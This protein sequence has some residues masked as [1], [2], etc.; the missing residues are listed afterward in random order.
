[1]KNSNKN[2]SLFK[3]MRLV[4]INEMSE[5]PHMN[6]EKGERID[7][8][9]MRIKAIST[10][11]SKEESDRLKTEEYEATTGVFISSADQKRRLTVMEVDMACGQMAGKLYGSNLMARHMQT[12]D[13]V[14]AFNENPL[15]GTENLT[16]K[17]QK[18]DPSYKS[19][20]FSKE[21][22]KDYIQIFLED[23]KGN[24]NEI[25]KFDI[26][27][28]ARIKMESKRETLLKE[29]QEQRSGLEKE[30]KNI[31][32]MK[33]QVAEYKLKLINKPINL[34]PEQVE[35]QHD[36]LV[37]GKTPET[38]ALTCWK[39][40]SEGKRM[41]KSATIIFTYENG[42]YKYKVLGSNPASNPEHT[43][44]GPETKEFTIP[45]FTEVEKLIQSTYIDAIQPSTAQMSG[46]EFVAKIGDKILYADHT[47]A[48][49]TADDIPAD[50]E[51]KKQVD[52]KALKRATKKAE[53]KRL[54]KMVEEETLAESAVEPIEED[55][56]K[57]TKTPTV[58]VEKIQ[59]KIVNK[60]EL[61]KDPDTNLRTLTITTKKGTK[62]VYKEIGQRT[63][64]LRAIWRYADSDEYYLDSG[65]RV[66]PSGFDYTGTGQKESV[67]LGK[68]ANIVRDT[69]RDVEEMS[70]ADVT[71]V[72]E[73]SLTEDSRFLMSQGPQFVQSKLDYYMRMTKEKLDAKEDH[74]VYSTL[75]GITQ[76][77][78]EGGIS[79]SKDL[80]KFYENITVDFHGVKVEWTKE[81]GF[82][83]PEN[84]D[85][86]L[87]KTIQMLKK[88]LSKEDYE[89]FR[90]REKTLER[91]ADLSQAEELAEKNNRENMLSKL[92]KTYKVKAF[93]KK[94]FPE[95]KML[96]N[97]K[98]LDGNKA[99]M[100]ALQR[101]NV[102]SLAQGSHGISEHEMPKLA[103]K[104]ITEWNNKR[105]DYKEVLKFAKPNIEGAFRQKTDSNALS[106]I[107]GKKGL[108]LE[109]M[110]DPSNLSEVIEKGLI[111]AEKNELHAEFM[112]RVFL[113]IV[114]PIIELLESLENLAFTK[115]EKDNTPKTTEDLIWGM[116]ERG[117]EHYA[118]FSLPAG[119]RFKLDQVS[120]Y[121]NSKNLEIGID[122]KL[123][124]QAKEG[125]KKQ[126]KE[127]LLEDKYTPY[128]DKIDNKIFLQ[129]LFLKIS[130]EELIKQGCLEMNTGKQLR[131][132]K[133][134]KEIK[135][136][137]I[138]ILENV[139]S[140]VDGTLENYSGHYEMDDMGLGSQD[141]VEDDDITILRNKL[142]F[143]DRQTKA[144]K[145]LKDLCDGGD[146][147]GWLKQVVD[148]C[149]G[150]ENFTYMTQLDGNALLQDR[151]RLNQQMTSDA[152]FNYLMYHGEYYDVD[153]VRG[154]K[155]LNIAKLEEEV[156]KFI[157][158]G[159]LQMYLS[160]G[161]EKGEAPTEEEVAEALKPGSEFNKELNELKISQ[162]GV[163]GLGAG[164]LLEK[165]KKAFQLGLLVEYNTK[166]EE[167][168]DTLKMPKN[169]AM[170]AWMEWAIS[171]GAKISTV[172]S[173]VSK[174][175]AGMAVIAGGGNTN[176]LFGAGCNFNL[177]GGLSLGVHAT[178]S[179]GAGVQLAYS[180]KAGNSTFT[181][182]VAVTGDIT[183]G[184][185]VLLGAQNRH[186][187][188]N[189]AYEG[190]AMAGLLSHSSTAFIP[191]PALA[192]G[193]GRSYT[194][195]VDLKLGETVKEKGF[196]KIQ[197]LLKEYDAGKKG[198]EEAVL[199]EARNIPQFAPL[200]D[201][202]IGGKVAISNKMIISL[203]KFQL[204]D[205]Q[206][207]SAKSASKSL[208][209]TDW[210]PIS[211]IVLGIPTY[212]KFSIPAGTVSRPLLK[213]EARL[214]GINS[215]MAVEDELE[216]KL[217][218]NELTGIGV[219]NM[220]QV[221]ITADGRIGRLI[222]KTQPVQLDFSNLSDSNL[223]NSALKDVNM[224]VEE[225]NA[226][227]ERVLHIFDA[228]DPSIGGKVEM[229]VH[230][231]PALAGELAI[232]TR[233]GE[234]LA[235]EGNLEN[236]IITRERFFFPA[237]TGKH[238]SSVKDVITIKKKSSVRGGRDRLNIQEHEAAYLEKLPGY[239][240]AVK[241]GENAKHLGKSQTVF[242]V[243]GWNS[244]ENEQVRREI[245]LARAS[246]VNTS[247]SDADIQDKTDLIQKH[248]GS[249]PETKF[250]KTEENVQKE[251]KES[252]DKAFTD[253]AFY[254]KL[255]T[256]IDKSGSIVAFLAENEGTIFSKELLGEDGILSDLERNLAAQYLTRRYFID[257]ASKTM[258]A[259]GLT[260][261]NLKA[262]QAMGPRA[263]KEFLKDKS[264]REK[265]IKYINSTR[266]ILFDN[267]DYVAKGFEPQFD[268]AI[269]R[270]KDRGV[271]VK[272]GLTGKKVA[273][274]MVLDI[275]SKVPKV[276]LNTKIEDLI[277][278][279]LLTLEVESLWEGS[280]ILY[281]T[282]KT[283]AETGG[284]KVPA[285]A[286][287]LQSIATAERTIRPAG[288]LK[289]TATM[290]E[291]NSNMGKV[292][293]ETASPV[294]KLA[295]IP[296]YKDFLESE[297]ARRVGG[298]GAIVFVLGDKNYE[299]LMKC[300][301]NP[302]I[303]DDNSGNLTAV[304]EF[305]KLCEQF[306]S[307]QLA[308]EPTVIEYK[309][310][311]FSFTL[312]SSTRSISWSDCGNA[313]FEAIQDG[314]VK[315]EKGGKTITVTR[316]NYETLDPQIKKLY[317]DFCLGIGVR[318]KKDKPREE[319]RKGGKFQSKSYGT[320]KRNPEIKVNLKTSSAKPIGT[321]SAGA[322]TNFKK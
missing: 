16:E 288:F 153:A 254:K 6:V 140:I 183:G 290:Y 280:T 77:I 147:R 166:Y 227:T 230:P 161:G 164:K 294:E 317:I 207:S 312:G 112:N 213:S 302:E 113:H 251:I 68:H 287:T 110:L 7:E 142:P 90:E 245:R 57:G 310:V 41:T 88:Y 47:G 3:E 256:I 236:L 178:A 252:M 240:W 23:D 129:A 144:I 100:R 304:R 167:Q 82:D 5:L 96:K 306:R 102:T 226:G 160:K 253:D 123:V 36:E 319:G 45:K 24:G 10:L 315:I 239:E 276:N 74:L 204:I 27:S 128:V 58:A 264:K 308:G 98:L 214:L 9:L 114:E 29:L 44:E 181:I 224:R 168:M 111:S 261:G 228:D 169:P 311:K 274:Q 267:A 14:Q 48:L 237:V 33:K 242:D 268:A 194:K 118:E 61:V 203:L 173:A 137:S 257:L 284:K 301:K 49:F 269:K 64:Q 75:E 238:G 73:P 115:L 270:L 188:G 157:K 65:L 131:L 262:L 222:S 93:E 232:H 146:K 218:F 119:N 190:L 62:L 196:E 78:S 69:E 135:K 281:G 300:F 17:I 193:A 32:E 1:M 265:F 106:E 195:A 241:Q 246:E 21:A 134:P 282:H 126:I 125:F 248:K 263:S 99:V 19:L 260:E 255:K 84:K 211:E 185:G 219:E 20:R 158:L 225:S 18:E 275:K 322:K 71:M 59:D 26:K 205:M 117:E 25:G 296:G 208:A 299:I 217:G 206:A 247:I 313:G 30:K 52:P 76:A 175:Q 172:K 4:F 216:E 258:K 223:R 298:L 38:Y 40:T 305:Q 107:M 145:Q 209:K 67:I 249:I 53:E 210:V 191:I 289:G 273:E 186:A 231:D 297:F 212:V 293:L 108:G 202:K 220:S 266:E 85:A 307:D 165:R 80:G 283:S 109:Y 46:K 101:F 133:L 94:H 12:L 138:H 192:Y 83:D 143:I 163:R 34:D 104:M 28:Q 243:Q 60:I 54:E 116:M 11:M 162:L 22:N 15:T 259:A 314:A 154:F 272:E 89:T 8:K 303:I 70:G 286:R 316:E 187:Y 152:A 156:N 159:A 309:D 132:I 150:V 295:G 182:G 79:M 198:A 155:T 141:W 97:W 271:E 122:Q 87:V 189:T 177:G 103:V 124:D 149:K 244:L 229:E 105:V 50:P 66:D 180:F 148:G 235:L 139:L 55:L 95:G 39:L 184:G 321:G 72:K 56:E 37:V 35:E 201:H 51:L 199:E 292:L 233:K 200:F 63:P 151:N 320:V 278:H 92:T 197:A 215:S 176:A 250:E 318:F 31:I 42:T 13:F 291:T 234:G 121:H 127:G 170:R 136:E 130:P 171:T 43:I 279:P 86:L 277:N 174:F 179:G 91:S 2:Y 221:Y 81:H 120:P 285:V